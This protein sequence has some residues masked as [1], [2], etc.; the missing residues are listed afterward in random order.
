MTTL[1]LLS[2]THATLARSHTLRAFH[3]E[4]GAQDFAMAV[5]DL[6]TIHILLSCALCLLALLA[7][8]GWRISQRLAE[9]ERLLDEGSSSAKTEA[10]APS[11]A[12]TAS[13]GAFETFLS[14]NPT[15]RDLPKSEQ[16]AAYRKWRQ[17]KGLNWS[18]S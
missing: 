17:E 6:T 11:A 13:G 1:K 16:F 18:G 7:L 10:P 3:H 5:N 12:E 15:R 8:I 9:I 14:E 4:A 2:H